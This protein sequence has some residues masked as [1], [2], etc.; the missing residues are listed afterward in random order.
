MDPS[1]V[2]IYRVISAIHLLFSIP[3]AEVR[4]CRDCGRRPASPISA[5]RFQWEATRCRGGHRQPEDGEP[6]AASRGVCVDCGYLFVVDV[7][8]G[9]RQCK[10]QAARDDSS[11]TWEPW[12]RVS[13]SSRCSSQ[14]YTPPAPF[15]IYASA[16]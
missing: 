9:R 7:I 12:P 4:T 10:V 2:D 3:A 13:P 14:C 11:S 15:R 6:A 8:E 5:S 1:D 16:G